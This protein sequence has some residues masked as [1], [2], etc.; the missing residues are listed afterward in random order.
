M[1]QVHRISRLGM[2]VAALIVPLLGLSKISFAKPGDEGQIRSLERRFADAFKAKDVDGI[3]ANYEHSPDLVFFDVVPRQE[4]LGWEAYRQAWQGLFASLGPVALFEVQ[5]L[6]VHVEGNLAYSYSFQH[7][8]AKTKSGQPRD[9]T[10][11]VTDVYRKSGGRWLIV[12]EHVS[13]PVDLRTGM[14]DLH[15]KP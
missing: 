9:V 8:R 15:F 6:T 7:Y 2:V 5:D 3:M 10:V 14:A 11:R 4:Y 12:Q 1:P 13:V